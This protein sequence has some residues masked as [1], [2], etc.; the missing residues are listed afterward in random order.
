MAANVWQTQ[1]K[2]FTQYVSEQGL[3]ACL[4][5]LPS[6]AQFLQPITGVGF[7]SD[8]SLPQALLREP[9][10]VSASVPEAYLDDEGNN[11]QLTAI[12]NFF[13]F[14]TRSSDLCQTANNDIFPG[15]D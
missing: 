15:A 8:W 14:R 6:P 10:S 3:E 1:H 2:S 11:S 13:H 5:L 12:S 4:S 7:P 9:F